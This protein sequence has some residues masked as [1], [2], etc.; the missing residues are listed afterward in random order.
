[1]SVLNNKNHGERGFALVWSYLVVTMMTIMTAA[2]YSMNAV[3]LK[4]LTTDASQIQALYLADS[5]V[6]QM[7]QQIKSGNYNAIGDTNLGNGSFT[8]TEYDPETGL[9]TA[10]GTVDGMTRTVTAV[11]EVPSGSSTPPGVKASVT[12]P[13]Q[14]AVLLGLRI[15]GNDHDSGG[16]ANGG[17]GTYGIAYGA[18]PS[19]DGLVLPKIGGNGYAPAQPVPSG[20]KKLMSAEEQTDVQTPETILGLASNSTALNTYKSS[21]T[22]SSALNNSIYY[23]TP[24]STGNVL[25]PAAS[26]NLNG[27]SGI[28]IVNNNSSNS[29]VNFSGSFTG[30]IICNNARF[31]T[32]TSITGAVVSA[33]TNS[34]MVGPLTFSQSNYAKI[35]YSEEVLENLPPISG[36][37]Q[38]SQTVTVK[39]WADNQNGADRLA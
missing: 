14:L 19:F 9:I 21:S 36:V 33:G 31:S 26:I 28:L 29:W 11:V 39:N 12:A 23:Y 10:T 35:N 16:T 20:A 13:Q 37:N 38:E 2:Y 3:E 27:G 1:M 25:V 8:V 15:D 24:S 4:Q 32:N 5:G 34:A 6:D 18:T 30:L 7:I 22:P 17:S